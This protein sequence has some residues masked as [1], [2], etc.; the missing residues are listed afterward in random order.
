MFNGIHTTYL[1]IIYRNAEEKEYSCILGQSKIIY[2]FKMKRINFLSQ[3]RAR[4]KFIDD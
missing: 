2:S 1:N 3:S 4:F